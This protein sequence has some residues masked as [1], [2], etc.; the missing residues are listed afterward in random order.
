MKDEMFII[1]RA[2]TN[3]STTQTVM[4]NCRIVIHIRYL[5]DIVMLKENM[6]PSHLQNND[7]WKYCSSL[8]E[9]KKILL[10]PKP[11]FPQAE[12]CICEGM[13][14]YEHS[15]YLSNYINVFWHRSWETDYVF[16]VYLAKV[17]K[18]CLFIL[19]IK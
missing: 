17:I 16:I 12:N 4:Q 7:I 18:L 11:Q 15:N 9:F 1:H 2:K 5:T 14:G 19:H 10:K 13:K 3:T 6:T 8:H